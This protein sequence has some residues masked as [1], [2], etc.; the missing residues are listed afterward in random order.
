[1]G[2]GL[3]VMLKMD[4][5]RGEPWSRRAAMTGAGLLLLLFLALWALVPESAREPEEEPPAATLPA[6]GESAGSAAPAVDGWDESRSIRLLRA[7]GTVEE[8]TLEDY[9]WGVTAAEMPAAFRSEALKAQAVAARTFCLYRQAHPVDRHPEVPICDDSSCC[10]AYL[11]P[12]EAAVIWGNEAQRYSDKLTQAVAETDGL[13]CL[14]GGEPINAVFFSSTAG[15][16]A[17]AV[18]VWGTDVPYLTSVDSPEGEEVPGWNTVVTFTDDELRQQVTA[19]RADIKLSGDPETWLGEPET[20]GTGMVLRLTVGGTELTGREARA[21]FG[22][23]SARFTV[24]REEGSF[25]FHVLGYGH[26]VGMSQYGANA[27]AG[28][29]KGFAE[30]LSWYY[31]GVTVGSYEAP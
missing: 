19:L 20:D 12:Q 27:L 22:L 7:D 14:Y 26:A 17:D 3:D 6:L 23:R 24:E 30:I 11:S 15:K 1:M 10:Q 31:T 9:L 29:G 25:S 4:V 21:L 16:T 8:L 5:R 13:V 2:K 18:T 28:Q